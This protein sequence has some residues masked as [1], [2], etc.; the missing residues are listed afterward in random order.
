LSLLLRAIR[1]TGSEFG[2][3]RI[4]NLQSAPEDLVAIIRE[5]AILV[6]RALLN[7]PAGMSN[8]GEWT[9]KDAC[10]DKVRELKLLVPLDAAWLVARD[11]ARREAVGAR[12]QGAQDDAIELQ[13]KLLTLAQSGYWRELSK[14]PALSS[15]ATDT[16][17]TL[18]DRASTLQGFMRI[19]SER[20]WRRLNELRKICE[21]AGF[22]S[23]TSAGLSGKARA[24]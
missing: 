8:I 15:L 24:A 10:W 22:Q 3:M 13:Q 16:Q 20:D 17:R 6:Q 9:K 1:N 5:A 4:W 11:D 14:W 23:V 19:A 12:K 7:P 18:V 21:D 2:C